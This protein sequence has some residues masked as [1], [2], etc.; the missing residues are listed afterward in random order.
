MSNT[1]LFD[2]AP[3]PKALIY[4]Q[5]CGV[6]LH[7]MRCR[8]CHKRGPINGGGWHGDY[9]Y[10]VCE[11][12]FHDRGELGNLARRAGWAGREVIVI[13]PEVAT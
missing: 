10:A 1:A 5:P 9:C 2:L 3:A 12:C 11:H 6:P 4:R 13:E 8:E 7:T